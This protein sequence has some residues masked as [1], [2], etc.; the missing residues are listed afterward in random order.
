[1]D[2]AKH[3]YSTYQHTWN[4][5]K[6]VVLVG[7]FGELAWK[8]TIPTGEHERWGWRQTRWEKAAVLTYIYVDWVLGQAMLGKTIVPTGTYEPQEGVRVMSSMAAAPAR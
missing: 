3:S 1:M 8:A 2:Y 5:G 7:K 6:R 4:P